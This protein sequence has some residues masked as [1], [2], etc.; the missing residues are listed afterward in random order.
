MNYSKIMILILLAVDCGG[1]PPDYDGP[2]SCQIDA[3]CV[4]GS[5]GAEVCSFEK[6]F[7]N[8]M[9][10][11]APVDTDF[12]GLIDADDP[13]PTNADIDGDRQKDG[14]DNCRFVSNPNQADVDGDSI[15]NACDE[16][17]HDAQDD[18]DDDGVCGDVDNCRYI[19]NA[20][21]ADLNGNGVGDACED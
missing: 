16:C 4:D 3:D 7:E 21:Q 12:D 6:P 15:G 5:K 9:G 20:D 11:C 17:P 13:S 10:R 1:P 14:H 18:A 19:Q 2:A 8:G